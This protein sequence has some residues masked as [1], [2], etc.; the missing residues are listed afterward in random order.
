[1]LV[2]P[3]DEVINLRRAHR[4]D[5]AEPRGRGL[6]PRT[7]QCARLGGALAADDQSA[8]RRHMLP[9]L[10][11]SRSQLQQPAAAIRCRRRQVSPQQRHR[12]P[13][14]LMPW[15]HSFGPETVGCELHLVGS[16]AAGMTTISRQTGLKHHGTFLRH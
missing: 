13:D 2:H 14:P 9:L 12:R 6:P 10:H 16:E 15:E 8:S 3:T 7:N 4:W 5:D 11:C 1:M